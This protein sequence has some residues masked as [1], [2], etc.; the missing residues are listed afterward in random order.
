MN[1]SEAKAKS[2]LNVP[3][4]IDSHVAVAVTEINKAIKEAVNVG[5]FFTTKRLSLP[6]RLENGVIKQLE[7][8][9]RELGYEVNVRDFLSM[10]M[11]Y[12]AW[13]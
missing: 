11:I 8:H 5:R 2:L 7:S 12:I 13:N 9:Y 3:K 1:A 6:E 10:K 4:L